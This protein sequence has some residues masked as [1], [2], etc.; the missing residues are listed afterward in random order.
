MGY[1]EFGDFGSGNILKLKDGHLQHPP[2]IPARPRYHQL[3]K[4]FTC[5]NTKKAKNRINAS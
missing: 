1:F 2:K 4:L 3:P 5:R